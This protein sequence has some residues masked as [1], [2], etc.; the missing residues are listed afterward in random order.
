MLISK[1]IED[2]FYVAINSKNTSYS[3]LGKEYDNDIVYLYLEIANIKKIKS[4]EVTD[5]MLMDYFPNQKNIVKLKAND[6]KKTLFLTK[7][8]NKESY[9]F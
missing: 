2:N 3:Y 9:T 7:D 8:K 6:S 1:Y 4:I 5:T